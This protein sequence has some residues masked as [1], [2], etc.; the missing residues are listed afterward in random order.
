MSTRIRVVFYILIASLFTSAALPILL[1]GAD[2]IPIGEVQP[3]APSDQL[4]PTNTCV[5]K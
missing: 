3:Q 1:P 2:A 4:S 5:G